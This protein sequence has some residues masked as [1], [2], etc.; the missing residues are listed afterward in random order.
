VPVNPW[1][2][3]MIGL[4]SLSAAAEY[5]HAAHVSLPEANVNSSTHTH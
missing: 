5:N 3:T 2:M 1:A 4:A